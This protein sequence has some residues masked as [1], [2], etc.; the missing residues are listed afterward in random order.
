MYKCCS[1]TRSKIVYKKS[2]DTDPM[3]LKRNSN[4]EKSME[5]N[6]FVYIMLKPKGDDFVVREVE[7]NLKT[8]FKK[9][10]KLTRN[11]I[12]NLLKKQDL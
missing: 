10:K 6:E 1:Q 12:M 4:P 7:G 9:N 2:G 5:T 8:N 3:K 11:D